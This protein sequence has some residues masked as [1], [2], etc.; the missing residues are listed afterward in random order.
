LA[1]STKIC[2]AIFGKFVLGDIL[3]VWIKQTR[4]EGYEFVNY[5]FRVFLD[6][7]FSV[8]GMSAK[9]VH[10]DFRLAFEGMYPEIVLQWR[11]SRN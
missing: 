7:C 1:N 11:L 2:V 6:S 9:K 3:P 10:T 8:A 4:P 5:S